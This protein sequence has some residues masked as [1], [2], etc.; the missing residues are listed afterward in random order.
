MGDLMLCWWENENGTATLENSL[1]FITL[2]THSSYDPEVPLLE[3]RKLTLIKKPR[4]VSSSSAHNCQTMETT[5]M[6][7]NW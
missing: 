2:I 4:N 7:L 3:K 1:V 6:P 5:Q